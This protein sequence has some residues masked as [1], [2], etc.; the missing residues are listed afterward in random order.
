M[1]LRWCGTSLLLTLLA[2]ANVVRRASVRASGQVRAMGRLADNAMDHDPHATRRN[3]VDD[4]DNDLMK[5][6]MGLD[7]FGLKERFWMMDPGSYNASLGMPG[8][9]LYLVKASDGDNKKYDRLGAVMKTWGKLM[10]DSNRPMLMVGASPSTEFPVHAATKCGLKGLKKVGNY[11]GAQLEGQGCGQMPG[12]PCRVA[13]SLALAAKHPGSWSWVMMIDDD[14][15]VIPHNVEQ[16]LAHL[17]PQKKQVVGCWGCGKP[18]GRCWGKGGFC[19]GCG[20][21]FSR[22]GLEAMVIEKGATAAFEEEHSMHCNNLTTTHGVDDVT[23]GCTMLRR[24]PDMEI[25]DIEHV[26]GQVP[27]G[28][29]RMDAEEFRPNTPM[30]AWH[31]VKPDKMLEIDKALRH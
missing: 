25:R 13:F 1:F 8:S 30:L 20:T 22:A 19:G 2:N 11:S 31:H 3:S 17:D 4:F 7:D 23:L 16:Y 24:V 9:V 12:L 14:H 29:Y 26:N 18:R 5:H 15:Y 28:G 21:A 6:T 10:V 27:Q